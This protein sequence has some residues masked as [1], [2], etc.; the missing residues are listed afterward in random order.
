[1]IRNEHRFQFPAKVIAQ[2]AAE[3]AQHH[4]QRAEVWRNGGVDTGDG[5]KHTKKEAADKAKLHDETA[6][7]MTAEAAAYGSQ[8]ERIYE[9]DP[10][11]IVHFHLDGTPWPDD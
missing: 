6:K 11:D 10:D 1:M 9:L 5:V 4:L 3:S 7:V 8:G 2:A